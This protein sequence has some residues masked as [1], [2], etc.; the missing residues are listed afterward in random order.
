M[1]TFGGTGADATKQAIDSVFMDGKIK[2]DD[3][4]NKLIGTTADGANVNFGA[5]NGML[6]KLEDDGRPWLVKIHCV[7]HRTEL[8][9]KNAFENS[10][11]RSVDK[12]YIG[13]F[14]LLKNSGAIKSDIKSAATSLDISV[15]TLP[16][17]T[18]TRFVS[19]RKK[20]LTH[21]LDM[22]PAIIT[23]LENTLAVRQHKPETRAK[24]QGQLKELK[25]Y[26]FLC[27]VCTYLDML[28]KIT[29]TS[30]TFEGEGL[31]PYE[32][33]TTIEMTITELE[34]VIACAGTDEEF[35]DS[36]LS[37]FRF[38]EN[39]DGTT[40]LSSKFVKTKNMLKKAANREYVSINL[41]GFTRVNLDSMA[42][43]SEAKKKFAAEL[44]GFIRVRFSSFNDPVYKCMKWFDPKNWEIESSINDI[45]NIKAF[46]EHF[47]VPLQSTLYDGGRIP[48]EFKRLR[49]FVNL[50]FGDK[51]TEG[52]VTAKGVWKNL[53]KFRQDQFPNLTILARIIL[54]LSPSNSSV[55]RCFSV[56]TSLLTD[57][58][59]AMSHAT[60]EM[61]IRI[62]GN[63]RVWT[64][65]EREEI[66]ERAVDIHLK[67]RRTK[68]MDKESPKKRQ[69]L[70]PV[71]IIDDSDDAIDENESGSGS[72][73][74]SGDESESNSSENNSS[75]N[76]SDTD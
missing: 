73:S 25:S 45:N 1:C 62:H 12:F 18:G 56:L 24:I 43:A 47:S 38:I 57:R 30:L 54:V 69:R 4:T 52:S 36:H 60:I 48:G 76:E 3:Y 63:N 35:L 10:K 9:V 74:S 26:P 68:E 2:L 21:L 8:A 29:P 49:V 5:Y 37:R 22:W 59:L 61:I 14:N 66:L 13:L 16:K 17:M 34:D 53:I 15:Y 44:I 75:E 6:K 70:N 50:N 7:N 40:S 19:H 20:A 65:N 23:A 33:M 71:E 67:K 41:E 46:A 51:M 31:L 58:R 55:E 39:E 72:G 28:E 42:K 27:L 32:V 11:F 64:D